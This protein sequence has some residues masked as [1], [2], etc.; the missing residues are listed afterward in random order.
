[1]T[2]H[3]SIN[4]RADSASSHDSTAKPENSSADAESKSHIARWAEAVANGQVPFPAD[5]SEGEAERLRLEV[6]LRRRIQLVSFIARAIARDIQDGF[7][8]LTGR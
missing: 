7:Q 2:S 8:T 4:T 1:M 5:L 3:R 6:V